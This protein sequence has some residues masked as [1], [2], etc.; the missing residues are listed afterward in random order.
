MAGIKSTHPPITSLNGLDSNPR[1]ALWAG[2]FAITL[3]S[4]GQR[5]APLW[6]IQF[7]T[8]GAEAF[9]I[10]L[11]ET[12]HVAAFVADE[13]AAIH[14]GYHASEVVVQDAIRAPKNHF[15]NHR[16]LSAGN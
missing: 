12:S 14:G 15:L 10:R 2:G 13:A 1:V 6:T 5:E 11:V 16:C 3:L 8:F 9:E 4:R 7:H